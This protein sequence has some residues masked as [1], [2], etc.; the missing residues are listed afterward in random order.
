MYLPAAQL[1]AWLWNTHP[2]TP[3]LSSTVGPECSPALGLSESG[4]DSKE[5]VYL[6]VGTSVCTQ[7]SSDQHVSEKIV[8]PSSRGELGHDEGVALS[9]L[10]G[11]FTAAQL[12]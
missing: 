9:V 2:E 6:C 5:D 4:L 8:F 7:Q 10:H 11:R 12:P 3:P 1:P